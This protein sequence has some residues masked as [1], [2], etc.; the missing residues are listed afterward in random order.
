MRSVFNIHTFAPS[1]RRRGRKRRM[2][3]DLGGRLSWYEGYMLIIII[4]VFHTGLVIDERKKGEE[5]EE[6]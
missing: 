6:S 2:G 5:E 1:R 4:M 3:E